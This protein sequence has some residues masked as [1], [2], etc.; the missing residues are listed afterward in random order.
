[1]QRP[2]GGKRA[3]VKKYSERYAARR[4]GGNW[5]AEWL[6]KVNALGDT[7]TPALPVEDAFTWLGRAAMLLVQATMA[8]TAMPPEQMRRD[9]MKQI[10]QAAKVLEPARLAR[11]ITELEI[12]L[13]QI[14]TKHRNVN[15]IEGRSSKAIGAGATR[16]G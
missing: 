7:S 8:D 11:R 6:A 9:A 12:A 1:M 16:D 10:E 13:T 4:R 2:S 3:T 15:V 14:Q 5:R